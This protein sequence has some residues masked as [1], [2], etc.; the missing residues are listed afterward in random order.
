M[1]LKDDLATREQPRSGPKCKT[2]DWYNNLDKSARQDF[3][4]YVTSP[5]FNRAHLH[6]VISEKWAYN[7]CDSSL[8]YHLAHHHGTG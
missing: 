2:C 1:T 6:R 7:N 5:E 4:D 8:K 3:D